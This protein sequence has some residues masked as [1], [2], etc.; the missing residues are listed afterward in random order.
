MIY[1]KLVSGQELNHI[2][3]VLES[4]HDSLVTAEGNVE[5]KTGIFKRRKNETIAWYINI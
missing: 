5:N 2:G 3:I 1:N 4:T